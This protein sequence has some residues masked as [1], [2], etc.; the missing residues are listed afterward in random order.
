MFWE[1]FEALFPSDGLEIHDAS[2]FSQPI[3]RSGEEKVE[4]APLVDWA[5][6]LVIGSILIAWMLGNMLKLGEVLLSLPRAAGT[7]CREPDG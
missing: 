7:A 4:E 6:E 2:C 1:L 5:P 3:S